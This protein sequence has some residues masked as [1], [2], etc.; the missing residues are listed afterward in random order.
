VRALSK[1]NEITQ[2]I[3]KGGTESERSDLIKSEGGCTFLIRGKLKLQILRSNS[4][5]C[6]RHPNLI[7]AD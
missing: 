1:L 3:K 7:F 6:Y 5:V 4:K 2:W